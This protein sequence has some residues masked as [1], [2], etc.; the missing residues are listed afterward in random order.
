MSVVKYLCEFFFGNFWH[1]CA[2]IL[3]LYCVIPRIEIRRE[4]KMDCKEDGDGSDSD[5]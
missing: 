5:E 1:F 3:F 4:K 2:L